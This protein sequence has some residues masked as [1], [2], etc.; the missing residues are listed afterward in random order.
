[1][2]PSQTW[3]PDLIFGGD[4]PFSTTWYCAVTWNLVVMLPSLSW[5][6][7]LIFGGDAPSSIHQ[8]TKGILISWYLV[9]MLPTLSWSYD[10]ML[11]P[12]SQ[13][14]H[15]FGG[16]APLSFMIFSP[17][18]PLFLLQPDIWWWCS[19][20]FHDLP[21]NLKS[22]CDAPFPFMICLVVILS[23]NLKFGG[24]A[25]SLSWSSDLRFGGDA[26]WKFGGDA[27]L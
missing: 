18:S 12:L 24:D 14:S 3:S 23:Y 27:L 2:L 26:L 19:L 22:G 16:D 4:T 13:T 6:S 9:V 17:G 15:L 5:S 11:P 7:D 21:H 8:R 25:P 10:L 20:P 1:M